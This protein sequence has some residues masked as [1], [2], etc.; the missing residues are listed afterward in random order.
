MQKCRSLVGGEHFRVVVRTALRAD[1]ADQRIVGRGR[2]SVD[3]PQPCL[4]LAGVDGE[5]LG[6]SCIRTER[7]PVAEVRVVGE[8]PT[9]IEGE[10]GTGWRVR[11]RNDEQLLAGRRLIPERVCA[12]VDLAVRAERLAGVGCRIRRHEDDHRIAGCVAVRLA[13]REAEIYC[14]ISA[15]G[16]GASRVPRHVHAD[17][18]SLLTG[19][20]HAE[21]SFVA[22]LTLSVP[23][24]ACAAGVA[25]KC[26]AAVGCYARRPTAAVLEAGL[27][28]GN[29]SGRRA[30]HVDLVGCARAL[31][32][33]LTDRKR[34]VDSGVSAC[35]AR[36]GIRTFARSPAVTECVAG[37]RTGIGSVVARAVA[38]LRLVGRA[39]AS[40]CI[41]T[42]ADRSGISAA[43]S[44]RS[45]CASRST[46]TCV[47]A[48]GIG[49]SAAVLEAG[50][51]DGHV[52]ATLLQLRLVGGARASRCIETIADR[53]GISAARS[54]RSACASRS[55][56]TRIRA[57]GVGPGRAILEAGLD[58][59]HVAAALL[60]LRLVG[61]AGSSCRIEAVAD[62]AG[63]SASG[64]SCSAR[65]S[66]SG[67]NA[68]G[69]RSP[70]VTECVAG[71]C[72]V[73]HLSRAVAVLRFV[74]RASALIL[75][76]TNVDARVAAASSS[77]ARAC[78]SARSARSRIDARILTDRV[79]EVGVWV[80]GVEERIG[81]R[82]A[83]EASPLTLVGLDESAVRL[84]G[85]GTRAA[86]AHSERSSSLLRR[87][88]DAVDSAAV[89]GHGEHCCSAKDHG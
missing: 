31:V 68:S 32:R 51:D 30:G 37:L 46:D 26:H 10:A 35:A 27:R 77:S 45:A 39:R 22:D 80:L 8:C 21:R 72:T 40:R 73:D 84:T 19:E 75:D 23:F 76:E 57:V 41:E 28:A 70:A 67:R 7:V 88:L 87:W 25:N 62:R 11:H 56:D 15:V 49:P 60:Q 33:I 66:G 50:L 24:E 42:I 4:A 16:V 52:A 47:G 38:G 3:G 79:G 86:S 55:T 48:I 59:G 58:D 36:S 14:S 29:S 78:R 20:V 83:V 44:S 65:A 69:A 5:I 18:G 34:S 81:N 85:L 64:S 1:R 71:L 89:G 17:H 53:S 43:R 63:V 12:V 6:A 54:S 13:S 9:R 82:R 74:G 61:G 2:S